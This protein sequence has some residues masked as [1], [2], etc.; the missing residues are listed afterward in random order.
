MAAARKLVVLTDAVLTSIVNDINFRKEFPSLARIEPTQKSIK[1]GCKPC[2]AHANQR[3]TQ[4]T[5]IKNAIFSF[6]NDQ[7]MKFK[8]ML[9][10]E[11]VEMR[12]SMGGKVSKITF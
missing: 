9:D 11:Q 2:Q 1:P 8:R 7:K 6:S 5:P 12:M 3:M 10:T 4:T